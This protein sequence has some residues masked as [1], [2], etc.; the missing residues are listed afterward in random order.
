MRPELW[1]FS[2]LT[3]IS[4]RIRGFFERTRIMILD[5]TSIL[6]QNLWPLKKIIRT[7]HVRVF[8]LSRSLHWHFVHVYN[9]HIKRSYVMICLPMPKNI[10]KN[11]QS[12]SFFS[13]KFRSF[14]QKMTV[15]FLKLSDDQQSFN[16]RNN[17]TTSQNICSLLID[18]MICT[19][20]I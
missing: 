1:N 18:Q 13:P 19:E 9:I 12:F 10:G 7:A 20:N 17:K 15:F 11:S 8:E 3:K 6:A 14:S 2:E 5:L 16:N 4:T